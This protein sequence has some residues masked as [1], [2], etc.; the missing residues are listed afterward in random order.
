MDKFDGTADDR[1]DDDDDDD[2]DDGDDDDDDDDDGDDGTSEACVNDKS[3]D[4][5]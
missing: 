5:V 4:L 2:G 3:K 1:Y